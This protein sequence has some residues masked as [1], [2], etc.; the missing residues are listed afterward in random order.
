MINRRRFLVSGFATALC[1]PA[2]VRVATLMPVRGIVIPSEVLHFGFV[3]RMY[4][5]LHFTKIAQMQDGG[6]SIREIARELNRHGSAAMNGLPWDAQNIASVL[7]RNEQIRRADGFVR[8]AK[9][10][11]SS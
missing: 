2:V 10:T 1:A 9:A 8:Q 11:A 5:H 7:M 3:D 4:V 6:L